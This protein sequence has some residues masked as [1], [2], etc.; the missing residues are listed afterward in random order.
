MEVIDCPEN[1]IECFTLSLFL[2]FPFCLSLSL[3]AP[4]RNVN[5]LAGD[6]TALLDYEVTVCME[7]TH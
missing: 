6:S 5:V 2:V 1:F 4:A 7:A 3:L